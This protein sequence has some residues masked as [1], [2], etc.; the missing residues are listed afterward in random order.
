MDIEGTKIGLES[1]AQTL[2]AFTASF[3][4]LPVQLRWADA[5]TFLALTNHE[6]EGRGL[7]AVINRLRMEVAALDATLELSLQSFYAQLT[8]EMKAEAARDADPD[9]KSPN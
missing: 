4:N 7:D 1:A 2:R 8:V 5:A 6:G 9:G 3:A